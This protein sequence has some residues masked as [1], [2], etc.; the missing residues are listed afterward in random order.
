MKGKMG[1]QRPRPRV[2]LLGK[3]EASDIEAF[4]NMFPTI[5]QA[6]TMN[7]LSHLVDVREIDLLVVASDVTNIDSDWPEQTHV[8]CFSYHNHQLP[9]PI[10]RSF[11]SLSNQA[12]TEGFFLPDVPLPLSRRR[13][14]DYQSLTSIRGWPRLELEFERGYMGRYELEKEDR[15]KATGIYNGGAIICEHH[16]KIPLAVYFLREATNLGV[17]WLPSINTNQAAWVALLVAQ[18]AQSNKDA[19]P[20]FGNWMNLPEWMV[21]EE[22]RILSK[23]QTLE[24]KKQESIVKINKQIDELSAEFAVM[25]AN[26]NKGLR[27]LITAQGQELVDE[28]AKVLQDIGFNVT[29]V[30]QLV[31]EGEPKKEDLRLVHSDKGGKQWNAIVEV[32]GYS[33]SAGMTKD[34]LRLAR[35][36]DLYRQETG[37]APDKRIYIING[38]FELPPIHRQEPLASA[39]DDLQIFAETDGILIWSIDLFRAIKATK[40]ANYPDLVESIKRTKGRWS[41][42]CIPSSKTG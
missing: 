14:A 29:C 25:K 22:V 6:D 35:F 42:I 1:G 28:V 33:R 36:A 41:P 16:T 23:I 2:A 27:R 21:P 11:L 10:P 15:E 5:W 20:N 17:A 3:F 40:S 8:I 32:R 18:W 34:L 7:E 13:E 31:D 38:Q 24:E 30:D 26:A 39:A 9:G 12:E 19:F 4:K 37:Q